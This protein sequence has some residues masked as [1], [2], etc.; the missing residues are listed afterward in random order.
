MA[1]TELSSASYL[2]PVGVGSNGGEVVAL[3]NGKYMAVWTQLVSNL[4]P[5][6]DV[7]D[8]D[9]M[10]IFGRVFNADGTSSGDVFQVNVT[11]DFAQND[12]DITTLTNGNVVVSWTD[13]PN[14][15]G[16]VEARARVL[17]A[18]GAPVSGEILLADTTEGDQHI[19]HVVGTA[20]G[21]FTAVWSDSRPGYSDRFMGRTFNADGTVAID[22]RRIEAGDSEDGD[23]LLLD[24]GMRVLVN[25]QQHYAWRSDDVRENDPYLPV[26]HDASG[27]PLRSH[28]KFDGHEASAAALPGG[29]FVT[30][31]SD[32]NSVV[33]QIFFTGDTQGIRRDEDDPD[34]F[35][36]VPDVSIRSLYGDSGLTVFSADSVDATFSLPTYQEPQTEVLVLEDGNILV[37]A[38]QLMRGSD[39]FTA[40]FDL[41]GRVVSPSGYMLTDPF[42]VQSDIP[43]GQLTRPFAQQ[44]TDGNIFIGWTSE[45][46]RNGDGT[47]ELAGTVF[48]YTAPTGTGTA[49]S[50]NDTIV[51]TPESDTLEGGFG[52]DQIYAGNDDDLLIFGTG[53]DRIFGEAGNDV[54]AARVLDGFDRIND[55]MLIDPLLDG[56]AGIDRIDLRNV[57]TALI[58][59]Q[60]TLQT[61]QS[62]SAF[63]YIENIE[64]FVATNLG[65][66]LGQIKA[67]DI[68]MMGGDDRVRGYYFGIG[69]AQNL[70]G[71]AGA[72]S[73]SLQSLQEMSCVGIC[74]WRG[75]L[76][77]VTE[78][79]LPSCLPMNSSYLHK[80]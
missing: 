79:F 5:I 19:P 10:A 50:G 54:F 34:F 70:D 60:S 40:E 15:D 51:G 74:I 64:H 62:P 41:M 61:A 2:A 57:Q 69:D 3:S 29:M 48:R 18:T 56:G 21:G 14:I 73:A 9:F 8:D 65:D 12:V 52:N 23:L 20:D 59:G 28:T 77:L 80:S 63:Q 26:G 45:S 66:D 76:A 33:M 36:Y 25:E 75:I 46:N 71:G 30:T 4:F 53:A 32:G 38:T 67:T 35:N 13:G 24:N 27:I 16:A 1:L 31:H 6:P 17:D 7:T 37:L 11:T 49:S 72:D 39:E 58:G 78:L 68:W 22:T 42:V 55:P 44:G 43:G 47:V